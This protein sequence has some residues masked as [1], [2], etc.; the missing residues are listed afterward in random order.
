LV[1]EGDRETKTTII[2][3]YRVEK[4]VGKGSYGSVYSVVHVSTGVRYAMKVINKAKNGPRSDRLRESLQ[5]EVEV[6]KKL[7]HPNLV[8]LWE[9][10]DDPRAQKVYMIQEYMEKGAV[11]PENFSVEPLSEEVALAVFVQAARGLHYLHSHSIC[12]GDIKPSN[13]LESQSG[14]IKIGD[15]GACFVVDENEGEGEISE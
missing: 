10:I 13:L 7:R 5:R 8:T 11:L 15:F 6:M 1:K 2:N 12:H 3:K 14:Q 9:V 4:E